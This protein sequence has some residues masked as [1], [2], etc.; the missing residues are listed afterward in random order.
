MQFLLNVFLYVKFKNVC[1]VICLKCGPNMFC[2]KSML[3]FMF[4]W[5]IN[6]EDTMF[7]EWNFWK[8][9]FL[10]WWFSSVNGNNS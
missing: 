6:Y 1:S 9:C 5:D 2:V 10:V 3:D 8:L 4:C 7:Y